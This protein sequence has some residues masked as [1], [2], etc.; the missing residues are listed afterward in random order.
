MAVLPLGAILAAVL[1][2]SG[3]SASRRIERPFT[4][5]ATLQRVRPASAQAGS[6]VATV[7]RPADLRATPGGRTFAKIGPRTEFGSPEIVL[8]ARRTPGWLGIVTPLA[9]NTG[10]GWIPESAAKL[11]QDQFELRV[12]IS[13][14]RLTVLRGGSVLERYTVAVGAPGSPTPV[15]RFAVTD[16]LTPKDPS[17]PYGCCILALSAKSP[18]AIQG[19]TGGNRI[20]IHSTPET[21]SIGQSVSHG[22]V[23]LRPAEARWLLGHI[24]LG[25]PT[26]IRS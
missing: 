16:R 13:Q 23:R 2:S 10:L 8:V 26:V 3:G 5:V 25:T 24:P 20:A 1:I 12:S 14:H 7:T 9:G 6:L 11:G 17:G 22:C 21:W 18:H 4:P 19:W 15:G